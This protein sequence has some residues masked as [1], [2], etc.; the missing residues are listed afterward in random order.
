MKSIFIH[1][2]CLIFVSYC[3]EASIWMKKKNVTSVT[4]GSGIHGLV[5]ILKFV[6]CLL[7]V[8]CEVTCTMQVKLRLEW[9]NYGRNLSEIH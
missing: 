2:N 6:K 8:Y 1:G 9:C 4:L 5:L 7:V 3:K